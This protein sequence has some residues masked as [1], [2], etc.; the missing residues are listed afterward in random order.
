MKI[1]KHAKIRMK[2]RTS[3]NHKE[4]RIIFRLA[5]SKGK[6]I[7]DIKDERIKRYM[8]SKRRYNSQSK[9]YKNYIFIYSRNSHQ[10]YT[11]YKLPDEFLESEMK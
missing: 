11:I 5:L 8:M 9:L 10:L 7:Q 1:S 6:S 3:L 4:R 2:E